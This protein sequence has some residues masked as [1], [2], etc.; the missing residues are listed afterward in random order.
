MIRES[1]KGHF[2]E[3]LVFEKSVVQW[4]LKVGE[5]ARSRDIEA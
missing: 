5:K 4:T 1:R 3:K 2:R